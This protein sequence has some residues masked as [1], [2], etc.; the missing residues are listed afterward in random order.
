MILVVVNSLTT[1]RNAII[2]AVST[3]LHLYHLADLSL[4]TQRMLKLRTTLF[5]LFSTFCNSFMLFP[6]VYL[7][8]Q[9]FQGV[10]S[11]Y[12]L[13]CPRLNSSGPRL[14]FASFRYRHGPLSRHL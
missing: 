4:S 13:N 6:T 12:P 5:F 1:K 2:P 11:L 8:P 3:C 9:F 7:L 10:S 14:D